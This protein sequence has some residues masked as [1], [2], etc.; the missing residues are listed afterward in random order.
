MTK[1]VEEQLETEIRD[2]FGFSIHQIELALMTCGVRFKELLFPLQAAHADLKLL[3][4]DAS[5]EKVWIAVA[6]D[7]MEVN[8]CDPGAN[9]SC[10]RRVLAVA[11]GSTSF[12]LRLR[13][14]YMGMDDNDS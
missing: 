9:C 6:S 4:R 13:I 11:G 7:I 10:A 12:G 3:V 2:A 14:P 5:A 1:H 8:Q